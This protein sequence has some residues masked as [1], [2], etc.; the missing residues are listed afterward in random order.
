M[1]LTKHAFLYLLLPAFLF[2]TTI[3]PSHAAPSEPPMVSYDVVSDL[4]FASV[5][6][7]AISF[8]QSKNLTLFATYDHAKNASD[9]KLELAPTTVLV[10]GSPLVGTKLMHAFP[11]IGMELPL[12]ILISQNADGKTVVTYPNLA[13]TFA[14]YGVKADHEALGIMQGLLKALATNA[15]K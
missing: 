7:K 10:F 2:F 9:V 4:P 5:V 3:H 8:I 1:S 6:D 11:G 15:S 14:P 13:M 12:K